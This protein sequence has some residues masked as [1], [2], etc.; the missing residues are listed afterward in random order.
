M[1][2]LL[3]GY[4]SPLSLVQLSLSVPAIERIHPSR[5]GT[6]S[7]IES[8]EGRSREQT[9]ALRRMNSMYGMGLKEV[10]FNLNASWL[11]PGHPKLAR[12]KSN[13]TVIPIHDLLAEKLQSSTTGAF[14]FSGSDS[15]NPELGK[16]YAMRRWY[17]CYL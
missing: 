3:Q 17:H 12:I 9:L 5:V 14:L 11:V 2:S 4:A 7:R 6:L 16:S 8:Q 10:S 13:A 15:W 1:Q